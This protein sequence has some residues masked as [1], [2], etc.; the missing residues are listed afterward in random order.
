[1]DCGLRAIIDARYDYYDK[2]KSGTLEADQ[3]ATLLTDLNEGTPPTKEEVTWV[4]SAAD[5]SA[6][7]GVDR[8]ELRAAIAVWYSR[9]GAAAQ[10]KHGSDSKSADK[11]RSS[12]CSIL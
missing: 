6:N 1:M 5:H 11:K 3:L 8:E 2:N 4:L 12:A 10:S 7:K 9:T